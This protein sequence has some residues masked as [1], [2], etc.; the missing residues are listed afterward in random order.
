MWVASKSWWRQRKRFTPRI[1]KMDCSLIYTLFLPSEIH[2]E[3]LPCRTIWMLEYLCNISWDFFAWRISTSP[4]IYVF[5]SLYEHRLIYILGNRPTLFCLLNCSH[6]DHWELLS[7]LLCPFYIPSLVCVCLCL[8]ERER[9]C[10]SVYVVGGGR[11]QYLCQVIQ[12][13][14]GS[15]YIFTI[16]ILESAISTKNHG[17]FYYRTAS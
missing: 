2:V 10:V 8:W 3:F 9:M 7:W 4:V 17:S 6:F 14:S 15:S 11:F 16:W 5:S 12:D 1:L 13:V